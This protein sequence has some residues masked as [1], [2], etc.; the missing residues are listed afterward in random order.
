MPRKTLVIAVAL[1]LP[2]LIIIGVNTLFADITR[3]NYIENT[4]VRVI[5]NHCPNDA[6]SPCKTTE[7]GSGLLIDNRGII[8]TSYETVSSTEM[9]SDDFEIVINNGITQ[10]YR[11]VP[12][13]IDEQKEIA[14]LLI[15]YDNQNQVVVNKD[16]ALS[17]P[18]F[19]LPILSFS[20]TVIQNGSEVKILQMAADEFVKIV[21]V[22]TDTTITLP[23]T[24]EKGMTG[25]P[26]MWEDEVIGI[27]VG[28][29]N[30]NAVRVRSVAEIR[31]L[32][33]PTGTQQIW[34][35]DIQIA[36]HIASTA[37]VQIT[38]TI[39]A[40]DQI[41]RSLAFL[42]YAF[43]E[44]RHPLPSPI[45]N[46][47]QLATH[48]IYSPQR[49]ADVQSLVLTQSLATMNL[50]LSQLRLRFLVWD[51]EG[52]RVLWRDNRWYRITESS[53]ITLNTP[54]PVTPTI[55]IRPTTSS[56]EC[57]EG[58]LPVNNEFCMDTHEVTN[59]EYADCPTCS[60]PIVKDTRYYKPYFGNSDFN[61]YPVVSVT[62][63]QAEEYC[64]HQGKL[65]PTADQWK[66]A[67]SMVLNRTEVTMRVIVFTDTMA[68]MSNEYDKSTN[69]IYDLIGNVR[70][71]ARD[72]S[73]Q[74]SSKKNVMGLS[75][76]DDPF[77]PDSELPNPGS[78]DIGFRCI[79]E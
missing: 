18:V 4:I 13:V 42:A 44:K 43:D 38:A 2:M 50:D 31:N 11:A 63:Q 53:P 40:L 37:T 60:E 36:T 46:S 28:K 33:W 25:A 14:L 48:K 16:F 29:P 24:L 34:V 52:E 22:V 7:F 70:E 66:Q 77:P 72:S 26:V 15:Y 3:Q 47:N 8:L 73:I 64:R 10:T 45:D 69:N 62:W 27:I 39:H 74:T 65:L 76:L 68:V 54:L 58:M 21:A 61:D 79:E 56:L 1:S 78:I 23:I 12:L 5:A 41:S 59:K 32:W 55:P 67:A 35:E 75:Y 30:E 51:V 19:N 9:F 20:D 71:W 57:A 6:N 49:F 17:T